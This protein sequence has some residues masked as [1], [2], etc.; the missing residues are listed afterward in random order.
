[1]AATFAALHARGQELAARLWAGLSEIR[2]VRLYGPSPLHPR[3]PT[4]SFTVEGR[5]AG[6]VARACAARG[7]FVS[8]GDFY[9]ATVAA[10]L[11]KSEEGLVR[12]GCACYTTP[13]EVE[14]LLE[15]VRG[16]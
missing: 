15:A 11:G 3:T 6:E 12:A 4:V 2:G 10:R 7:L 14:R 5:T 9:A 16:S 8:H 13:E 1:L